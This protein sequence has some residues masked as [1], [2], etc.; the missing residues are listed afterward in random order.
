MSDARKRDTRMLLAYT[1]DKLLEI[2]F[3]HI[4]NVWRV[5]GL[6]FL[7]IEEKFGT[8]AAAEIDAYCHKVLGRIEAKALIKTLGLEERGIPELITALDESMRLARALIEKSE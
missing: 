3:T 2:F 1:P 5:D 7:G 6:Y 4:R 8:Q